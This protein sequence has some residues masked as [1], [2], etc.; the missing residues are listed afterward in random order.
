MRFILL[1]LPFWLQLMD[2]PLSFIVS[3]HFGLVKFS[4]LR[5]VL[6]LQSASEPKT[7]ARL[8]VVSSHK[9]GAWLNALLGLRM[10]DEAVKIAIGLCLEAPLCQPHSC[11]HCG[12]YV[13]HFGTHELSCRKSQGRHFRHSSLNDIIHRS[14]SSASVPSRFI[15]IRWKET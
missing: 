9:S 15:S 14:L 5:L 6:L 2:D 1:P 10:N 12:A 13:D 7:R 4:T 11:S 8:L 3:S